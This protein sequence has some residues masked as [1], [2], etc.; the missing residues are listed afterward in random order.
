MKKKYLL[1]TGLKP[2]S[3]VRVLPLQL[4]PK[5]QRKIHLAKWVTDNSSP[6]VILFTEDLSYPTTMST[7]LF[8]TNAS[9]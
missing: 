7:E 6:I 4:P 2:M 8:S 5:S 3:I 1:S 9:N